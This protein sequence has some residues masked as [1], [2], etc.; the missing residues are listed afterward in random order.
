MNYLVADVGGTTIKLGFYVGGQLVE[1]CCISAEAEQPMLDRLGAIAQEWSQLLASR[2]LDMSDVNAAALAL[3]FLVNK[4]ECSVAGDFAKFP[5]AAGVDYSDWAQRTLGIPLVID[6]DVRMALLGEWKHG[7][8]QGESNVAMMTLGTGIGCAAICDGRMIHG[9]KDWAAS[10]LGH[11]TLDWDAEPGRCGNIGCAED[12]A[13]TATLGQL[14]QEN[15]EGEQSGPIESPKLDFEQLFDQADRGDADSQRLIG[16]C[17]K[18]WSSVALNIVLAYDP[19]VL[20]LG[21]GIL[22]RKETIIP[23][24]KQRFEQSVADVHL[25]VRVV[26][27]TLG[28]RAAL[29]GSSTLC[30][31]TFSSE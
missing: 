13:S 28:D 19:S 5:G 2:Q 25:D 11:M 1:A 31:D 12:L 20:V 3:P 23:A 22:R 30:Q 18:V 8:A 21:G 27:G 29:Y 24:F 10:S 14:A 15:S 16:R 9:S 4:S 7:V 26:A 17:L 6:N